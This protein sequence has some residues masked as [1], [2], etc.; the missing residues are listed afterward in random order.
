METLGYYNGEIGVLEDMR[1]PM[2]DRV[3]WFGDGVYDATLSANHIIFAL[4]EHIDRFFNSAVLLDMDPPISEPAL[5]ELLSSLVRKV[6]SP[7]QLVYWQMTRGTASRIHSFPEKAKPNLWVMLRP[8]PMPD[9][10][11]KVGLILLEDTRYLHCNIKTLNLIPNVLAAEKAKQAGAYEAVFHRSDRV[12]ECSHS[13]VHILKNGVL[14]TAPADHLILPGISRAHLIA[15]CGKLGI[16][17]SETPF[18]VSQML[19]ADEILITSSGSFCLSADRIDGEPAGGKAPE[20][21]RKL[22]DALLEEFYEATRVK[23]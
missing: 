3:C 4:E 13:N 7:S 9:I 21:V 1:I 19:A 17:V 15:Q 12:T 10:Y 20:L 14:Y 23:S 5:A 22:Q 11:R 6:D 18:A 16:P 2:N 8:C